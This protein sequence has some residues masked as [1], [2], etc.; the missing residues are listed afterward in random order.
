MS[1][2]PTGLPTGSGRETLREEIAR[3]LWARDDSEHAYAWEPNAA[4]YRADAEQILALP[5]LAALLA[6]GERAEPLEQEQERV[7]NALHHVGMHYPLTDNERSL[8]TCAAE[9]LATPRRVAATQTECATQRSTWALRGPSSPVDKL[10]LAQQESAATLEPLVLQ[11]AD[12]LA[13]AVLS[14]VDTG[15]LDARSAAA[16]ALLDYADQRFDVRDGSGLQQL[17]Y[18]LSVRALTGASPSG[19]PPQRV[20]EHA[21]VMDTLR[22]LEETQR[23]V[24]RSFAPTSSSREPQIKYEHRTTRGPRK[25]WD[26]KPDLTA[27]G[28][29]L[30]KSQG[31]DGWERF[32]HHEEM[33]WR[34][35]VLHEPQPE[36]GEP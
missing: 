33:Y 20:V 14:L 4:L 28:W 30:D 1:D 6:T 15:A 26:G 11:G 25:A 31:R 32:D 35:P 18:G 22:L 16:D 8:L 23:E 2:N 21:R 34:R 17:R 9:W 19:E 27:E 7:V 24:A 36:R 10:F 12:R 29:E 3:A 13:R 5:S